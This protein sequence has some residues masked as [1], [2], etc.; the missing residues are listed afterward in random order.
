M[1][2]ALF[3]LALNAALFRLLL[4]RIG[5]LR[6]LWLGAK[7]N[8]ALLEDQWRQIQPDLVRLEKCDR[9]EALDKK[10][11]FAVQGLEALGDAN[12]FYACRLDNRIEEVRLTMADVPEETAAYDEDWPEMVKQTQKVWRALTAKNSATHPVES[13]H[14]QP[15]G[16]QAVDQEL[17][18]LILQHIN[19]LTDEALQ[20]R[21][22]ESLAQIIDRFLVHIQSFDRI[23]NRYCRLA[24]NKRIIDNRTLFLKQKYHQHMQAQLRKE[25]AIELREQEREERIVAKQK[26]TARREAE[27]EIKYQ[28]EL[29]TKIEESQK[30]FQEEMEAREAL[31]KHASDEEKER[32]MAQMRSMEETHRAKMEEEQERY[33]ELEASRLR[34]LSFAETTTQ[35]FIYIISNKGSFGEDV[36]KIGMTR[37]EDPEERIREL[38]DASVPFNFKC[39]ALI[40][41]DTA[42]TLEHALHKQFANFRMNKVNARK[43]FFRISFDTITKALAEAGHAFWVPRLKLRDDFAQTL[44]VQKRFEV[45]QNSPQALISGR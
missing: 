26:E 28:K 9:L 30:D 4:R 5:T 34:K 6:A 29:R 43:E 20:S 22:Q 36:F 21:G 10:L 15:P 44:S 40:K 31:L 25:E 24:L 45:T 42:P 33:R 32:L 8:V 11:L 2:L 3:P 13:S 18:M 41:S 23:L 1:M 39:H 27:K 16:A 37:R 19:L 12:T 14:P 17:A 7:S 38:S 35:G